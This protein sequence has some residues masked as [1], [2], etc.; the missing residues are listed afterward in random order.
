MP[1]T[2]PLSPSGRIVIPVSHGGLEAVLRAPSEPIAASFTKRPKRWR[3][4]G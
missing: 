3:T 2:E 1:P 4:G